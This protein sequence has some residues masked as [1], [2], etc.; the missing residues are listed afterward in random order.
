MLES[1]IASLTRNAIDLKNERVEHHAWNSTTKQ[2]L[3]HPFKTIFHFQKWVDVS[4]KLHIR[5]EIVCV[6]LILKK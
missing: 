4:C 3:F 2:A 1:S 5:K 6:I